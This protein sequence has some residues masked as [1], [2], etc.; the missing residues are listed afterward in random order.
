MGRSGL[1][2]LCKLF[3]FHTLLLLVAVVLGPLRVHGVG[4]LVPGDGTYAV[5][6]PGDGV[7]V[8]GDCAVLGVDDAHGLSSSSI[9]TLIGRRVVASCCKGLFAR[10]LGVLEEVEPNTAPGPSCIRL[11]QAPRLNI[12]ASVF[13][14]PRS[15][16]VIFPAK[17][18]T[19]L[20]LERIS[21]STLDLLEQQFLMQ[22]SMIQNKIEDEVDEEVKED[23]IESAYH[24]EKAI[25]KMALL[26]YH[27][28][29]ENA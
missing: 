11:V 26:K 5:D 22:L 3:A 21:M 15:V 9:S 19:C 14:L 27:R 4:V 8:L 17:P 13:C 25:E 29:A 10:R 1:V 28:D 6:V 18:Y 7:L 24:I 23:L 2:G 16:L 12:L 20:K